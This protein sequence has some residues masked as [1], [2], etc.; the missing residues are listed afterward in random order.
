MST[1]F[2]RLAAVPPRVL[3]SL[4]LLPSAAALAGTQ[5]SGTYR[6]YSTRDQTSGASTSLRL[7]D[8]TR[9]DNAAITADRGDLSLLDSPLVARLGGSYAN[10]AVSDL[11]SAAVVYVKSGAVYELSLRKPGTPVPRNFVAEREACS[12]RAV[13]SDFASPDDSGVF[14]AVQ[15]ADGSCPGSGFALR[16]ARFSSTAGQ[17]PVTLG[18]GYRIVDALNNRDS[19]ALSG[20]LLVKSD[21]LYLAAPDLSDL[22]GTALLSL[23][24]G[25]GRNLI[26]APALGTRAAYIQGVPAGS[27]QAHLWRLD[28]RSHSLVD[29]HT[30]AGAA[31][32]AVLVDSRNVYASDGGRLLVAAHADAAT[33]VLAAPSSTALVTLAG[34]TLDRV[35]Y[36]AVASNGDTGVRSVLKAGGGGKSLL[37]SS[38]NTLVSTF[39]AGANVYIGTLNSSGLPTAVVVRG[40]GS[41]AS[42]KSL[43]TWLPAALS[44]TA[45][46]GTVLREGTPITRMLLLTLP[47]TSAITGDTS[48][49]KLSINNPASGTGTTQIGTV[50][51]V[52]VRVTY[53]F[54]GIGRYLLGSI[55]IQRS[56]SKRDADLYYFDTG[57]SHSFQALAHVAGRDE[58]TISH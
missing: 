35:I 55:E 38:A 6:A 20:Y 28:T 32:D 52:D 50:K 45:P 14:Y 15:A 23:A 13:F 46:V 1:S 51:D 53:P 56:G 10:R 5:D 48:T 4:L 39:T 19:G 24:E 47:F 11:H 36:T 42:S 34:Q 25:T 12:V 16:F 7:I 40:D 49:I 57:S 33:T 37:S 54:Y 3:A 44:T 9:P 21:V 43:S 8:P 26:A 31:G 58:L 22:P 27:T 41:G 17:P 30:D 29:L 18:T 2:P